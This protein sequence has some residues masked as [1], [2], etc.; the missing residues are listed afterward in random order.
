MFALS[1]TFGFL[2][3]LTAASCGGSDAKRGGSG[4]SSDAPEVDAGLSPDQDLTN[5]PECDA[6][7]ARVEAANCPGV[8]DCNRVF[9]CGLVLTIA[10]CYEARREY[11]ACWSQ[12]QGEGSFECVTTDSSS[13]IS[14]LA[15]SEC[16]EQA[17]AS[18]VCADAGLDAGP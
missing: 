2:L 4:P 13:G 5:T 15:S 17:H 14:L 7:C 6:F 1:N 3:L 16:I 18:T 11:L 12:S 10:D 8:S 9:W